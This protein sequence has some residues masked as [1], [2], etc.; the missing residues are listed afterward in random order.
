MMIVEVKEFGAEPDPSQTDLL[1]FIAQSLFIRGRNMHGA[2]T[3]ESLRL[4]S[5]ML[6]RSVLVRNFGVYLLQFEQTSPLDSKWIKWNRLKITEQTLVD[7]LRMDRRPDHPDLLMI[8]Y[9]RNRHRQKQL[10]WEDIAP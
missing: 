7:L 2:K 1:S 6:K 8:D 4:K 3:T 5:R 9:L 10:S